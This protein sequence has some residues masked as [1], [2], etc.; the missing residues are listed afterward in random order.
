MLQYRSY[1]NN[2][3]HI[4][5]FTGA[6]ELGGVWTDQNIYRGIS[7]SVFIHFIPNYPSLITMT[8][9]PVF[10]SYGMA[11]IDDPQTPPGVADEREATHDRV[12]ATPL[13][14][15]SKVKKIYSGI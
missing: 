4:R 10:S 2:N 9:A 7:P 5:D 6:E 14:N 12:S 13:F 3:D 15:A 1:S 8:D 11:L